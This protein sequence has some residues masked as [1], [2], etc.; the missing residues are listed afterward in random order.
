LNHQAELTHTFLVA[1][2]VKKSV[3]PDNFHNTI[4]VVNQKTQ[5]IFTGDLPFYPLREQKWAPWYHLIVPN[6]MLNRT[7]SCPQF[8]AIFRNRH[9][10]HRV[11]VYPDGKNCCFGTKT[12]R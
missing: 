10:D 6:G 11:I 2:Q 3:H 4:H 1:E 8:I 9:D 12:F 5:G 7:L